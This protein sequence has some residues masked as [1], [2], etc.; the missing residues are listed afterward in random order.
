VSASS[1]GDG[2][3]LP[4]RPRRISQSVAR[5][6][7]VCSPSSFTP[8][9]YF[10]TVKFS[11]GAFSIF[12]GALGAAG[13]QGPEGPAGCARRHLVIDW[14]TPELSATRKLSRY[15]SP[16]WR[17]NFWIDRDPG[18]NPKRRCRRLRTCSGLLVLVRRKP[19]PTQQVSIAGVGADVA[20]TG[21]SAEEDQPT[22]TLLIGH[23]EELKRLR[24]LAHN[25]IGFSQQD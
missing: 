19:H 18:V 9:T 11:I 12:S 21:V 16:G 1:S 22:S 15:A 7:S 13:P 3:L 2:L 6:P 17:V 14:L 24:F 5:F 23:V 20:E 4:S 10:L 8:G 25:A